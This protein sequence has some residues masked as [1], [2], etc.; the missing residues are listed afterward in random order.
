MLVLHNNFDLS[1]RFF[2]FWRPL[3]KKI[4]TEDENSKSSNSDFNEKIPSEVEKVDQETSTETSFVGTDPPAPCQ[5]IF[6]ITHLISKIKCLKK[7]PSYSLRIWLP[8]MLM[9]IFVGKEFVSIY[10]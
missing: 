1:T 4:K 10:I 8:N 2:A 6:Y 7:K 9:Q 3:R 5:V